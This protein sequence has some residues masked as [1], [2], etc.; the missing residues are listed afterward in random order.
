MLVAD[1]GHVASC[2]LSM[3]G[4]AGFWQFWDWN[5]LDWGNLGFVYVAALLRICFLRDVGMGD[6]KKEV[7]KA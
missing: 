5:A 1:V 4:V 6:E 7:K 2:Y 3:P